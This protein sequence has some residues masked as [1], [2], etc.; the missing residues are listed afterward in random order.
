[1]LKRLTAEEKIGLAFFAAAMI[2]AGLWPWL[3]NRIGIGAILPAALYWLLALGFSIGRGID[4]WKDPDAPRR[5]KVRR[6]AAIPA[7]VVAALIVNT[8]LAPGERLAAKLSLAQRQAEMKVAQRKAGW[9]RAAAIPYVEGTPDGGLALIR[10]T[11]GD[12]AK[13]LPREHLRLTGERIRAC[14]RI[15]LDDWLCSYD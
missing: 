9:G 12:P 14:R 4:A 6:M 3:Y 11:C 13:L 15:G 1:M 7:A 2:L 8:A 5:R 10:Y